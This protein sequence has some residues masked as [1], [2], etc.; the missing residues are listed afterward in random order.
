MTFPSFIY[1]LRVD[2]P[3]NLYTRT[4]L[5]RKE[6]LWNV[7]NQTETVGLKPYASPDAFASPSWQLVVLNRAGGGKGGGQWPRGPIACI[8]LDMERMRGRF[9][10]GS[11]W[12]DGEWYR[13]PHGPRWHRAR[14]RR[15]DTVTR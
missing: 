1:I 10:P 4:F 13:R 5:S 7:F 8:R 12:S 15:Y 9:P 14:D 2:R 11:R 3:L 6:S